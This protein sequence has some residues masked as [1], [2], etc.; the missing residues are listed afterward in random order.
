MLLQLRCRLCRTEQIWIFFVQSISY[1]SYASAVM[2]TPGNN[3]ASLLKNS[4]SHPRQP[5]SDWDPKNNIM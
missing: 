2:A 3:K 5:L 1:K 4:A